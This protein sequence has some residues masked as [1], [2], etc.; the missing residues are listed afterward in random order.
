MLH[1]KMVSS[2]AYFLGAGIGG[3]TVVLLEQGTTPYPS[4][5]WYNAATKK[6]GLY[7]FKTYATFEGAIPGGVLVSE[8]NTKTNKLVEVTLPSG[9]AKTLAS[10]P[11][12]DYVTAAAGPTA[13]VTI[14]SSSTGVEVSDVAYSS[15]GHLHGLYHATGQSISCPS[16]TTT[17]VG[18]ILLKST[19]A[20]IARFSFS[21]SHRYIRKVGASYPPPGVVVTPNVTAWYVCSNTGCPL[22]RLLASN[23]RPIASY[24]L[25]VVANVASATDELFFSPS[26]LTTSSGGLFELGDTA[27][28]P[29]HVATGLRSALAAAAISVGSS[30]ISWIDNAKGGL[31]VWSRS[32][33][34]AGTA[35]SLGKPKLLG[36]EGLVASDSTSYSLDVSDGDSAVAT[37]SYAKQ[38]SADPLDISIF[39]GGHETVI[40]DLGDWSAYGGGVLDLSGTDVLFETTTGFDLE[41][42][43]TKHVTVLP[44]TNVATYAAGG[45]KLAFIKTDGSVWIENNNLTGLHQLAPALSGGQSYYYTD[46]LSVSSDGNEVAWAYGWLSGGGSGQVAQWINTKTLGTPKNI[47]V[48]SGLVAKVSISPKVLGVGYAQPSGGDQLWAMS[49]PS[50]SWKEYASPVYGLSIGGSVAAWLDGNGKPF[51]KRI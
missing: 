34:P 46:G 25:P 27:K 18:C 2:S 20:Q 11:S 5:W 31:G 16:V 43:A 33:N 21:G 8:A 12:S 50:G 14:A 13:A 23:N 38:P 37:T 36:G 45:G 19:T 1:P 42:I 4:A 30:S 7:A 51:V 9:K 29:T 26:N 41:T 32:Y 24:P 15:P 22:H 10:L 39:E 49:L 47:P 48:R 44:V 28:A 40:S 3:S 6:S 35:L 17:A